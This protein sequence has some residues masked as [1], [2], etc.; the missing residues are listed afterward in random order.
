MEFP[1]GFRKNRSPQSA[2]LN[3]ALG[4]SEPASVTSGTVIDS[5]SVNHSIAVEEMVAG[6][7]LEER[8]GAVTKVNAVN[9]IGDSSG[10]GEVVFNGLF[11]DGSKVAG[12]L[13]TWVGGFREWVLKLVRN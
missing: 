1:N 6:S 7:W 10:D 5:D 2:F 8:I 3:Q 9:A 4:L 13:D 12:D 11:G